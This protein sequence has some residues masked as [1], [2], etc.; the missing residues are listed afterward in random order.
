MHPLQPRQ[1]N[2]KTMFYVLDFYLLQPLQKMKVGD[3]VLRMGLTN[4]KVRLGFWCDIKDEID[5]YEHDMVRNF[6]RNVAPLLETAVSNRAMDLA[7][8]I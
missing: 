5:I 1:T 4:E 3:T 7:V 8:H 6:A 2:V